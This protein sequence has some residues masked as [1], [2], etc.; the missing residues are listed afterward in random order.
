LGTKAPPR[1]AG[2]RI[3]LAYFTFRNA[4]SIAV[5]QREDSDRRASMPSTTLAMTPIHRLGL[6]GRDKMDRATEAATFK[7]FGC[8]AHDLILL[9]RRMG[10]NFPRKIKMPRRLDITGSHYPASQI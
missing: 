10:E 9:D 8:A 5:E 7:L 3:K 2:R 4:I 6:T 1:F